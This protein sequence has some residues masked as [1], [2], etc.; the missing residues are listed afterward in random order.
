MRRLCVRLRSL[1]LPLS[2]HIHSIS[3][4]SPHLFI[5]LIPS[6]QT[7]VSIARFERLVESV[8]HANEETELSSSPSIPSSPSSPSSRLAC[9]PHAGSAMLM[10]HLWLRSAPVGQGALSL[11]LLSLQ[12]Q[13]IRLGYGGA[14]LSPPPLPSPPGGQLLGR[15]FSREELSP[16][17]VHRAAGR[18]FRQ[19]GD[20][21]EGRGGVE[22]A[23]AFE[24]MAAAL[25][26]GGSR[27]V[28]LLQGRWG[29]RWGELGWAGDEIEEVER[30]VCAVEWD[31]GAER[32]PV[33]FQSP[34]H[35]T[36]PTAP[37]ST[38][39]PFALVPTAPI[40]MPSHPLAL[41]S[42]SIP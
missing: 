10:K 39:T 38:R 3:I 32:Q 33:L 42:P 23:E 19:E 37:A 2:A 25:A 35:L 29:A 26:L 27:S 17:A 20:G 40:F 11:F 22:E 31:P 8:R 7:G 21:G 14:L 36:L 18:L 4:F 12:E 41:T 5:P 9:L 15:G 13:A 24:V 30:E 6:T 34:Y 1:S 28:P 16:A